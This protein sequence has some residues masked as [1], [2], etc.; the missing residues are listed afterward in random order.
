M[1]AQGRELQCQARDLLITR[2]WYVEQ[3]AAEL[4]VTVD[5]IHHVMQYL[6]REGLPLS[7]W[8]MDMWH[9]VYPKGR[10]C[11]HE[12]CDT[13]LR[14]S[15]PCKCCESHGGGG[16]PP[17]EPP[18]QDTPIVCCRCGEETWDYSPKQRHC[19]TCNGAY[20]RGEKVP[21]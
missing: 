7:E 9:I 6:R 2:A 16:Y 17:Y 13:V 14:Q 4:G 1:S 21:A 12:G 11:E 19:R 5:S 15:N 3:L 18:V 20:K 10:V 8:G